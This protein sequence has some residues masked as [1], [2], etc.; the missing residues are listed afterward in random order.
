MNTDAEKDERFPY[1][2]ERKQ[3]FPKKGREHKG[4][5]QKLRDILIALCVQ[6]Q[7]QDDGSGSYDATIKDIA[8]WAGVSEALTKKAYETY[9]DAIS[10][11]LD[12]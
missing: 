9:T 8:S 4:P 10:A 6:K 1:Y 2:F 3:R 7:L 11:S 12:D 5:E